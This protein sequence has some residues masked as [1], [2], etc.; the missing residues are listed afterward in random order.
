[1]FLKY[2]LQNMKQ[3]CKSF[4]LPYM[5][6]PVFALIFVLYLPESQI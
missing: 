4:D 6:M 1:M 2:V 3:M 5:Y